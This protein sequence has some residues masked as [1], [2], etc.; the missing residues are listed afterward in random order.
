MVEAVPRKPYGGQTSDLCTVV[1]NMHE[2]RDRIESAL[3]DDECAMTIVAFPTLGVGQF[4]FPFTKPGGIYAQSDC[5][6][7]KVINPHPRFWTLTGNIRE[8]RGS[9][10]DIRVPIYS[11]GSLK[12]RELEKSKAKDDDTV[13]FKFNDVANSVEKQTLDRK[14][15]SASD[16]KIDSTTSSSTNSVQKSATSAQREYVKMDCMAL[17]WVAAYK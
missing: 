5:I 1:Q 7:D 8:R 4:T 15:S 6:S 13:M 16:T 14:R 11:G 17:V 3:L 2:R 10:V 9:K 12:R